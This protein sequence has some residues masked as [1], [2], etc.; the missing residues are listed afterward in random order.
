[1]TTRKSIQISA[2]MI[3]AAS[4]YSL[5]KLSNLPDVIPVHWNYLGEPDG[6]ASKVWGV[7]LMPMAMATMALLMVALPKISPKKFE[8]EPLSIFNYVMLLVIGFLGVMHVVMLHAADL[9]RPLDGIVLI[10]VF[11][12]FALIGNVLGKVRRNFWMGVRTPW[13]LADERVWDKTHRSAA[14]L[15]TAGGIVGAVLAVFGMRPW[16]FIALVSVMALFPIA[17]SYVIYRQLNP[18]LGNGQNN[19]AEGVPPSAL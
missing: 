3:F 18:R 11:V 12:L 4:A 9:P 7:W 17:Q 2:A 13:T 8:L 16:M 10:A 15:W 6:Y 19:G 14:R 1:M 5:F